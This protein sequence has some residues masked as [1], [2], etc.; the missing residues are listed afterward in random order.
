MIEEE[1]EEEREGSAE[2]EEEEE[3]DAFG[4]EK[5]SISLLSLAGEILQTGSRV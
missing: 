5:V 2:G 1:E 4:G 3:E